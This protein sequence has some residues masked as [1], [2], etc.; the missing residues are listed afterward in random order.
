MVCSSCIKVYRKALSL[1]TNHHY[2]I[3]CQAIE[4]AIHRSGKYEAGSTG[5]LEFTRHASYL[6]PI[7]ANNAQFSPGDYQNNLIP[8]M[9]AYINTE[10]GLIGSYRD[11]EINYTGGAINTDKGNATE[12]SFLGYAVTNMPPYLA[13]YVWQRIN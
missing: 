11:V 9:K 13:V 6:P 5:G 2:H 4:H 8:R 3:K 12:N 10:N 1:S 7:N